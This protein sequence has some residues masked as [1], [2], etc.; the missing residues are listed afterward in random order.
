MCVV[1]QLSWLKA[2]LMSFDSLYRCIILPVVEIFISGLVKLDFFD[3]PIY[4]PTIDEVRQVIEEEEGSFTLETLKTIKM[5][6]DANLQED[7]DFVVDSKMKGELIAKSI[8]AVFETLLSAEFGED[9]MDEL[10]S[11]YAKLVAKLAELETLEHTNVV[12]SITKDP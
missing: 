1:L 2:N 10:F 8:R 4:F 5:G 6:W 9:I 7:V 3:L 12:V 11:R